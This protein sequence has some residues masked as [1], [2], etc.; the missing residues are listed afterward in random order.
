MRGG[1]LALFFL[2]TQCLWITATS[3]ADRIIGA[4]F[5]ESSIEL[6]DVLQA[7]ES[8]SPVV[9][10]DVPADATGQKIRMNLTAT[11]LATP[12]RWAV[13]TLSNP[14]LVARDFVLEIPRQGFV[15]SGV[16]WPRKSAPRIFS[17]SASTGPKP[18]LIAARNAHSYA[19]SIGPGGTASFAIE[20]SPAILEQVKLWHRDAYETQAGQLAF[21]NGVVLGI[22][23]LLG[24]A[25]LSLFVVR[26]MAVFPAA[27]VFS[28]SMIGFMLL[29]AG[30]LSLIA[31]P[32]FEQAYEPVIRAVVES[33]ML[34][35]LSLTIITILQLP[36]NAALVSWFFWIAAAAGLG[37]A[38]FGFF[39]PLIATGLARMAF[40]VVGFAGF[41]IALV[42][43]SRHISRAASSMLVWLV[44]LAW[45]V[46]AAIACQNLFKTEF[47]EPAMA[48]GQGLVLIT[49]SF[50]LVQ[51]VFGRTIAAS[52]FLEDSGRRALALAG[53][54]QSVWDWQVEQ[55]E[56]YVGPELER[57]LGLEPGVMGAVNLRK[58]HEIIHPADLKAYISTVEAAEKRGIGPFSQEFRLRR[59]DGTYRWFLLRARAIVGEDHFASRLIGTM[60]DITGVK[61][62]QDRLLADAVRDRVTGL[63]NR[64]LFIDRLARAMRREGAQNSDELFVLVID[65]DRFK[66]VNDGLGHEVGDSLLNVTGSRLARMIGPDDT[67]ARLAGDQFGIIF[68]GQTPAREIIEVTDNVGR[69]VAIPINVRP[70]EIFLTAC[71]GIAQ[72][73]IGQENPEELL[74]NA[75]IALYEAKRKGKDQIEFFNPSMRDD[76]S[77]LVAL[78]SDLQRALDRGEI[79][80][81][82]QPIKRLIDDQLA[83][84]EALV[85]WRHHE[86]GLLGPDAFLDIAEETGIIREVGRYVLNEAARQLGI[87]QRAFRPSDPLFVAVNVSRAQLLNYELVSDLR[88]LLGR[89]DI[90]PGTLKLEVTETLVMQNPELATKVLER[91]SELGVGIA[92]DDF[93]TGYSALAN[94]A[95]LPFDTLKV[96]RAFLFEDGI[97]HNATIVFDAITRLAH[98]LNLNV[99][100]EG[101]E[102]Q[103]QIDRL[104]HRGVDYAQGFF[105]GEPVS[106]K[107]VIEALGGQPYTPETPGSGLSQLW[108][109][110]L[111]RDKETENPDTD[112]PDAAQQAAEVAEMQRQ[113]EP[114]EPW[115]PE[116][117]D[118]SDTA[119]GEFPP[120][121]PAFAAPI[122]EAEQAPEP[123]RPPEPDIAPGTA[124]ESASESAGETASEL[125]PAP[126]VLPEDDLVL[127]FPPSAP[128]TSPPAEPAP[129][130]ATEQQPL[131]DD[132]KPSTPQIGAA[133]LA[134][135]VVPPEAVAQAQPDKAVARTRQTTPVR[136]R[137]RKSNRKAIALKRRRRTFKRRRTIVGR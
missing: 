91:A 132:A 30:F 1:M 27:I 46:L 85:R 99:V 121:E 109:R 72:Y 88:A 60:T 11:V 92:C 15:N 120:E 65:L 24:I 71:I 100:A 43:W 103:E 76:R 19:L 94:L 5:K 98:D 83:G 134:P 127:P 21:F 130:P 131:A 58:W 137:N 14:D 37:L 39:D 68:N 50:T 52:H 79:E 112:L 110:L 28:W 64:A 129:D 95:R 75:E 16:L 20:L 84:F 61:R 26:P 23:F 89:E 133:P 108:N 105:V 38:G 87:W 86:Q 41:F 102:S 59:A 48:A 18:V 135:R 118:V 8:N 9:A 125:E 40:A 93:G 67:L 57:S 117:A 6:I 74:K 45:T 12:H 29:N 101:V 96:D 3:A 80:V 54:E 62:S 70:R 126:D 2:L 124:P 34:M 111:G 33:L 56:L 47:L 115:T 35:G 4:G 42:L 114:L 7:V 119:S 113:E 128:H 136:Q 78:E 53:S 81:V 77:Q 63:P 36:R 122:A 116:S 22:A 13:F 106:A 44:I 69:I 97:N 25:I 10:I 104:L 82:Y 51:L 55:Q 17:V 31:S 90:V 107:R 49:L 32:E 66:N 73:E 123:A